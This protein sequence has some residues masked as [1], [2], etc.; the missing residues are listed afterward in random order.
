MAEVGI[1]SPAP[2]FGSDPQQAAVLEFDDVL[3]C[4]RTDEARPAGTRI[5]FVGG[6]E[7]RFPR[8]DIDIKTRLFVIPEIV[9]KG[10]LGAILLGDVILEARSGWI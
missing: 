10:R 8:D 7:E 1:T 9:V 5:E 2:D 6:A 3:R 4:Y